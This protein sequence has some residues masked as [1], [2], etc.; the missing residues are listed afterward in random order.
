[1]PEKKFSFQV[2]NEK[3][4][5]ITPQRGYYSYASGVWASIIANK[6]KYLGKERRILIRDYDTSE[7]ISTI[8]ITDEVIKFYES[9]MRR[10]STKYH[11]IFQTRTW[12]EVEKNAYIAV[13]DSPINAKFDSLMNLWRYI[14][15]NREE[16]QKTQMRIVTEKDGKEIN[17]Q[18]VTAELIETIE[19]KPFGDF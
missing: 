7:V 15:R 11:Y 8:E 4:K 18:E 9:N 3:G 13:W 14:L 19:S 12:K 16:Y 17:I 10:N 6:R 2:K 5:W 1:M